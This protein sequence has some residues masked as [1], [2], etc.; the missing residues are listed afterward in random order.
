MTTKKKLI[1]QLVK[2][3]YK[4]SILVNCSYDELAILTQ[5]AFVD[6]YWT[7]SARAMAARSKELKRKGQLEP[8]QGWLERQINSI[9]EI[10]DA[11]KYK[12]DKKLKQQHEED[13]QKLARGPKVVLT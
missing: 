9:K 2:N 11:I 12:R 4:Q 1:N 6:N 3:G 13:R 7:A 10:A 8:K 5:E